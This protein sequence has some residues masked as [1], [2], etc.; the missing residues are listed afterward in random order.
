MTRRLCAACHERAPLYVRSNRGQRWNTHRTTKDHDL[1]FRCF[2]AAC[3]RLAS[4][5]LQHGC[6]L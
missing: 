6:R 4:Y 3:A 2:R 1:C 5:K